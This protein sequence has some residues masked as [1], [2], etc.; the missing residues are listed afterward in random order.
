MGSAAGPAALER[1]AQRA[2]SAGP[3]ARWPPAAAPAGNPLLGAG[4]GPADTPGTR[5]YLMCADIQVTVAELEAKG[6]KTTAP[7]ADQGWGLVTGIEVPG[8]GLDRLINE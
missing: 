8:A 5:L 2:P 6:V 1:S 7:I 3:A 4:T